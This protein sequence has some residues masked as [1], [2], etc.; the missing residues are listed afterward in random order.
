MKK[1]IF[2][3]LTIAVIF[4][5]LVFYNYFSAQK[6]LR[7]TK[8]APLGISLVSFPDVLKVGQTGTFVWNVEATSD[9]STTNTTIYWGPTASPSALTQSNAP[10]AVGYPSYQDDFHRGL[11]KLPDDF[12]VNITFNK[13]GVV[14]FRAY[15]KVGENHLWTEEHSIEIMP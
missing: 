8:T 9:K 12:D 10:D 1:N 11:F 3:L 13:A 5:G 14:Y 2:I 15:A 6:K 7:E 4:A